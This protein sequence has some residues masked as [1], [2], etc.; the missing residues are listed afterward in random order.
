MNNEK[1]DYTYS[2]NNEKELEK[3]KDKYRNKTTKETKI[4]QLVEL[5]KSVNKNACI[6]AMSMGVV[7]LLILGLGMSCVTVWTNYFVLGIIIGVIGLVIVGLTYPIYLK[8]VKTKK[9]E[10]TPQIIRLTEEIERGEL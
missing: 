7:G 1:F 3:I 2:S 5:D 8:M 10:I 9:E 4:Q 6:V